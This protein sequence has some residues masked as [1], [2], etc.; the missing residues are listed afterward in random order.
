MECF[1]AV[2]CLPSRQLESGFEGASNSSDFFA[3]D[4]DFPAAGGD[5]SSGDSED[6][7][8]AMKSQRPTAALRRKRLTGEA[9]GLSHD[10]KT[11]FI[12][13]EIDR[14]DITGT[15]MPDKQFL[16]QFDT[17]YEMMHG[18]QK[19]VERIVEKVGEHYGWLTCCDQKRSLIEKCVR[20]LRDQSKASQLL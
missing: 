10:T 15:N 1:W 18:K 11:R 4:E 9:A 8:E 20:E 16:I 3:I 12:A 5:A 13:P 2:K 17:L 19:T 14:Q 7:W 6:N